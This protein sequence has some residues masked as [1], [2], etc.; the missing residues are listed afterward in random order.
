MCYFQE[1]IIDTGIALPQQTIGQ[2]G[3]YYWMLLA[4]S[5]IR[6]GGGSIELSSFEYQ[7]QGVF[8]PD[9][10]ANSD[11]DFHIYPNPFNDALHIK[12]NTSFIEQVRIEI[13]DLSGRLVHAFPSAEVLGSKVWAWNYSDSGVY[14][15]R[16]NS[17]NHQQTIKVVCLK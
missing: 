6:A 15:V 2:G 14:L 1:V 16:I 7:P 13:F 10:N 9:F 12:V 3:T 17:Q 8:E 11:F 4:L 5:D